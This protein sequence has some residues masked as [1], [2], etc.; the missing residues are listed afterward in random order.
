MRHTETGHAVTR[1]L[2]GSRQRDVRVEGGGKVGEKNEEEKSGK[3]D[4]ERKRLRSEGSGLCACVS[5]Q[6]QNLQR[7]PAGWRP[8][9]EQALPSQSQGH[10]VTEFP[11][12]PRAQCSL[13]FKPSTDAQSLPT[14]R[15]TAPGHKYLH[16][17]THSNVSFIIRLAP[18]PSQVDRK[19]PP[20]VCRDVSSS[21][22]SHHGKLR[23]SIMM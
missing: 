23:T 8:R 10:Q 2:G 17:N 14:P 20:H 5:M 1:G 13:L 16:R 18:Q 15:S 3:G 4:G 19:Q 12:V 9:Q 21:E 22:L 11:L 6:A 7:G